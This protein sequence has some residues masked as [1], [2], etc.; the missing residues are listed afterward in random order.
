MQPSAQP[1][2]SVRALQYDSVLR[3]SVSGSVPVT[4]RPSGRL[5]VYV[6]NRAVLSSDALFDAASALSPGSEYRLKRTVTS[7]I[8]PAALSSRPMNCRSVSSNAESGMLLTKAISMS[9][10]LGLA[11]AHVRAHH[12][13]PHECRRRV[14]R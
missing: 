5:A 6:V 1:I 12:L 8:S 4:I 3:S 2:S 10:R 9:N 13:P 14:R 7:P 11:S